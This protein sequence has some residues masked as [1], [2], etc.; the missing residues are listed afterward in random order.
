MMKLVFMQKENSNNKV[1]ESKHLSNDTIFKKYAVSEGDIIRIKPNEIVL[2][3]KKGKL[4]DLQEEQGEYYINN[5]IIV[6][7][8]S[9]QELKKVVIR[10]SEN[11]NLCV[12]FVNVDTIKNNKYI[13]NDPIK[14]IDWKNGEA[15]EIYIKIEGLYDFKIENPKKFI[16]QVIGLRSIY[17]KQELVE[18][19]RKY[20]LS[21]IE[22]GINEVSREYK[23]DVAHLPEYSKKLEIELKQNKY[24]EKLSEY[25]VKITYFDISKLEVAK[26]KFKFFKKHIDN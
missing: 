23:L 12:L 13:F 1:I 14:Y 6:D 20:V 7:K 25:G 26:K 24:D 18:R 22:A 4:L 10:K 19:I 11:E 16:G 8:E 17:T 5:P 9:V 2:L 21:S 3:I 15:S